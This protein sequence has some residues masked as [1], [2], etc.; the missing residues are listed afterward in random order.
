M[1]YHGA[2]QNSEHLVVKLIK[3]IRADCIENYIEYINLN[4]ESYHLGAL[5]DSH[6][7][8]TQRQVSVHHLAQGIPGI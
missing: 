1:I 6:F 7:P 2:I 8:Q 3:Q 4:L 5:A